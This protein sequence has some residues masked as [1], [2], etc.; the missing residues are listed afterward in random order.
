MDFSVLISVYHKDNIDFFQQALESVTVGQ[1]LKPRQVVIVQDGPVSPQVDAIIA[2]LADDLPEIAFTTV[3]KDVNA[4][5]AAALNSGLT[6]CKYDW[7]ARMDADD[8]SA[9]DRFEKQVRFVTENPD[10]DVVGGTIAEFKRSVGDIRSERHVGLCQEEI[11]SMAKK[12]S[13]MNH[14]T[15]LYRKSAVLDSGAYSENFGK[16]EDYKLW[17]D[18][19]SSGKHFGNLNDVLVHVRI[20]NGFVE[21]RS[22][23]REIY[24]W[25]MLQTYLLKNR[26][27]SRLQATRNRLYIRVF[28]YMPGWAKKLLYKSVLRK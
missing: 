13:P 11:L 1:T 7:V 8:I 26:F 21:R 27:I 28:I 3:K 5:L 6:V 9:S 4:G 2:A 17:V 16:L 23:R 14:V 19:L 24:D 12:R 18:M 10:I 22:N 25:D 15:V 20:G